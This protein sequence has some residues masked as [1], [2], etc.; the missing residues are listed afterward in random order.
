MTDTL[1]NTKNDIGANV[2]QQMVAL[3]N[4]ALAT[5]IDLAAQTKQA[6]WN[7]RG[8]NFAGLHALFDTQNALVAGMVD[9]IAERITALGGFAEGRVTHIT[10]SSK[11]AAYPTATTETEHLQALVSAFSAFSAFTRQGVDAAAEKGDQITADLLTGITRELDKQLWM[12][13]AHSAK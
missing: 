5:S 1:R 13:E 12:L 4:I 6:H 11:L 7:V 3:L 8:P 10:S 2:R 9:E